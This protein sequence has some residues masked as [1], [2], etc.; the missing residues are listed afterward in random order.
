[1]I[2]SLVLV[3]SLVVG[4][5]G[6]NFAAEFDEGYWTIGVS[7]G[8]IVVS[9]CVQLAIFRWRRGSQLSADR[10]LM[11]ADSRSRKIMTLPCRGQMVLADAPHVGAKRLD[12][13][14]SSSTQSS[15][16][17]RRASQIGARAR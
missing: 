5:Y 8:L 14:R 4:F 1:M 7:T 9:T 2:A 6:Q 3:P 16:R 12:G 11:I 10:D 15:H 17:G 13:Q